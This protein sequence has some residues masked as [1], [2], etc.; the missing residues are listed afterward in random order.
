V[1]ARPPRSRRLLA[2][3]CPMARCVDSMFELRFMTKFQED[4]ETDPRR[5]N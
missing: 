3:R 2:Y 1:V 5:L 4:E